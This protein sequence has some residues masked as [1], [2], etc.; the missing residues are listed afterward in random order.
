MDNEI[1]YQDY[2]KALQFD[3]RVTRMGALDHMTSIIID[4]LKPREEDRV[5]DMGTG[6]GRLG[7]VLH[8]KL[9]HGSVV[10]IDSGRGMLRVAREKIA[11]QN[12]DNFLLVRGMAETLP[13]LPAAFDSACLM[14]SFHHFT[15][16]EKA[17]AELHRVLKRKGYLF[18]LDPVL[19][20]PADSDDRRLNEAIE[21]AFQEAHGPEF[22]FFTTSQLRG[23]YEAAGFSIDIC[24]IH[25]L[26]FDRKGIESVPMG[27]HWAQAYGNLAFRRQK[28]LLKKFEQNYFA[29]MTEGQK[30]VVTGK[31]RWAT[32]K[33]MKG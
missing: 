14:L 20:E 15:S 28:D 31:M 24:Q 4:G 2:H 8:K 32:T 6:T 23:L 29:F 17:T 19:S 30:T 33:A 27:P 3:Q 22:R 12:I 13:F 1:D 18:S 9:P 16:P 11:K 10:G 25:E 26:N 5:L 21:E 7:M